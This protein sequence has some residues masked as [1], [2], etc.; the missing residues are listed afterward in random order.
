MDEGADDNKHHFDM[1]KIVQ[2]ETKKKKKSKS[3]YKKASAPQEKEP[4]DFMVKL[5]IGLLRI[6]AE[7]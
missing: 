5:E 3:R 6:Q 4:D 1:K 7:G 2:G